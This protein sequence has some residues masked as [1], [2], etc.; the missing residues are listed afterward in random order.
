[1]NTRQSFRRTWTG[2]TVKIEI[3]CLAVHRKV[4]VILC[5]LVTLRERKRFLHLHFIMLIPQLS[6]NLDLNSSYF[7]EPIIFHG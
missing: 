4:F 6:R 7:A 2:Y 5:W 3:S 1:M